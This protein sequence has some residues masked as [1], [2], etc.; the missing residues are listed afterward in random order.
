[1]LIVLNLLGVARIEVVGSSFIP[2]G[3]I[4][5]LLPRAW[6]TKFTGQFS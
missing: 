1:M 2:Q 5:K 6:K 4:K 3:K